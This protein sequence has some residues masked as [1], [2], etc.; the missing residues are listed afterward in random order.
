MAVVPTASL[1]VDRFMSDARLLGVPPER[2][3][4]ILLLCVVKKLHGILEEHVGRQI[5]DLALTQSLSDAR[6]VIAKQ[7]GIT[8]Q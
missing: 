2:A 6:A 4:A 3:A 5:A 7:K 1:G 8:I